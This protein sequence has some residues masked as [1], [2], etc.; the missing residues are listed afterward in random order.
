MIQNPIFI[1]GTERSGSNLLRLLLNELSGVCVPHPPH[2]MRDLAPLIPRYGT[3]KED[4]NFRRLID[5]AVSLV[6][7]H[8]APWP[9][10]LN[11]EQVFDR[12]SART[13]Y[14]V[15]AEIYEQYRIYAHKDRWACKSTFMVHHID[16]ILAHH[17]SPQFIHLVRDPRDVAVSARRSIFSHY[18]PYFVADLWRREQAVALK[19]K[20]R[21]A[22]KQWLTVTYEQLISEPEETMREICAFLDEKYSKSLLKFFD[23]PAA[24]ELSA[25]SK[26]WENV[27][28]PVMSENKGKYKSQLTREEIALIESV[29][30][31]EMRALGYKPVTKPI[32]VGAFQ[33]TRY[34]LSEEWQTLRGETVA[35]LTDRNARQ[36]LKKK[37]FL[38]SLRFR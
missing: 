33:R 30:G 1:V 37:A 4:A 36:R 9:V 29:A 38:W 3:L 17:R 32:T 18:H 35:L 21:L 15:Y 31:G 34:Q 24:R 16:E 22:K 20:K 8:F 14:A 7:M 6:E 2:L 13:L 12:A 11:R 27:R 19:Y 5:D 25:L 28:K 23:K 10:N 26:S